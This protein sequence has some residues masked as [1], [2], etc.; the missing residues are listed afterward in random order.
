[1]DWAVVEQALEM[2]RAA[3]LRILD[4]MAGVLA[5]PRAELSPYAPR[6]EV[7]KIP[8]DKIGALIGPGGK[9]IRRITETFK[10]EADIEDDG[11]VK[12]YSVSKENMDAA[13]REIMLVAAEAEVGKTYQ[14]RV[15]GIKDFGCFVEILPGLEG[16]VHISELANFR[17]NA[18]ED[19]CKMG[20]MMWVKCLH[21]DDNGKI[22][23]S[24]RA[25]LE[26]KDGPQEG[27]GEGAPAE[28]APPRPRDDRG[29]PRGGPRGGRDGGFR[30]RR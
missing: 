26:E 17:V 14:G 13:V 4:S 24:R 21:V 12:V 25:A 7:L 2:A 9:N 11:T 20:D 28:G 15:T 16:L 19:V 29:G 10:V 23:L 5:E 30:G 3:R 22:R 8:V 27:G 1:L 18:V 6:V